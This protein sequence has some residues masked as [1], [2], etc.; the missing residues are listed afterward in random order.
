MGVNG[1]L[2]LDKDE[3][4]TSQDCVSKLRGILGERRIGHAGTLDPLATGLLVVLVGRA[5]R[6]AAFAEAETKEYVAAFRPGIVTDTQDITGNLLR[7]SEDDVHAALPRFTGEIEQIPPMY[8]AI[9]INGRKLYDIARRGGEV[10]R[11]AR[12][13]TIHSIDYLGQKNGDHML[14]IRCSKGT[15]IRTLCHDLGEY[16]GCGG[17]MAALRRTRSGSF[18]VENA[19][20]IGELTRADRDTL[21][22]ADTLFSAAASLTLTAAQEKRCRCGNPF[23]TDAPDGETRFYS[24]NGEFLAI[25]RVA[26]GEAVTVKSFF[27]V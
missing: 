19:R 26:N 20:R 14:R 8:S 17:C 21:L 1:I 4:W 13:I 10:E 27:E 25:G 24:E 2:L 3:G 6:A 7:S 22:P 12:R 18:S 5:T 23:R 16:L 11:A 9:K 15:Y